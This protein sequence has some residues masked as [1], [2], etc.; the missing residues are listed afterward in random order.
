M[1]PLVVLAQ[2]ILA[3]VVSVWGPDHGVN[4]IPR[5]LVVVEGYAVQMIELDQDDRAVDPVVEGAVILDATHPHEVGVG[6]MSRHLRHFH[7]SM[8]VSHASGVELD[9]RQQVCLYLRM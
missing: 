6:E 9:Q 1:V 3:V 5:W 4:V 8:S 7:A 2:Q